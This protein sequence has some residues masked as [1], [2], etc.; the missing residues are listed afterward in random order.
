M[1]RRVTISFDVNSELNDTD[2]HCAMDRAIELGLDYV[3]TE[4]KI[5]DYDFSSKKVMIIRKGG[6]V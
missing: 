4:K 6:E 2:L 3:T 5:T 1:K